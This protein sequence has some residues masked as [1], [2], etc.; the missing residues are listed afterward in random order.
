MWSWDIT[1]IHSPWVGKSFKAYVIMDVFS[2]RIKGFRVEDREVDELAVQMFAAAIAEH[3]AP[4]C[5]HADSGAAMTSNALKQFLTEDHSVEMTHNRP[6]V[7]NDNPFSEAGFKTMKYRPTY[8]RIFPDLDSART[9]ITE[10][11]RWYNTEHRHSGIALFTPNE[12]DD[13]TWIHTWAARQKV[14][15]DYH[16]AHPARFS[17]RPVTPAPAEIV[18]INL[19]DDP[20]ELEQLQNRLITA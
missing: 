8:P 16:Q 2:R 13:G 6:Y 7:S 11:V 1:D 5:V 3:G 15:I 10:Y 19:P 20:A 17:Q 12:V 14:L 4:R 18:G 9:Y